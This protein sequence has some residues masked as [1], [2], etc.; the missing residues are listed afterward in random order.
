MGRD[1]A[2]SPQNHGNYCL[3]AYELRCLGLSETDLE[4]M[5]KNIIRREG[6]RDYLENP[7][8]TAHITYS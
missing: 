4:M 7:L 5:S 2:L 1:T 3:A 8:S 6:R